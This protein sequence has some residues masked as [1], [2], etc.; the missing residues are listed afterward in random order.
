MWVT[1]L[2]WCLPIV[3]L[4]P[5]AYGESQEAELESPDATQISKT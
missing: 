4:S 1:F 3:G 5:E 2:G